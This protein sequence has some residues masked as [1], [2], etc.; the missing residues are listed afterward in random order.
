M[1]RSRSY[2]H[3]DLKRA[4]LEAADSL[5][6]SEG[7]DALT[8]RRLA[9]ELGVSHAAPL[10]HFPDRAALNGAIAARACRK[11]G[12]EL[13]E[14]G[15]H[16]Y[17]GYAAPKPADANP[18]RQATFLASPAI[19]A[20]YERLA[21][22]APDRRVLSRRLL[23][24]A[25]AW[26]RF[27]VERP[28]LFRLLSETPLEAAGELAAER[29]KL[30]SLMEDLVGLG[31]RAGE[32]RRGVP[33]RQ[34]ARLLIAVIEGLALRINDEKPVGVTDRLKDADEVLE[35]LLRGIAS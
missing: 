28:G 4:I 21:P 22:M 18:V 31:Q 5:I 29:A 24:V 30:V 7:P 13:A 19:P 15:R 27:A 12:A 25:G 32:L 6:E 8:F 2:H 9:E 33:S 23:A 34:V 10:A 3:G 1:S 35:L 14:V 11:L 16:P 26:L 20:S 17:A